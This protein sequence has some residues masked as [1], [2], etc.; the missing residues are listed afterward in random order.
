MLS[1]FPIWDLTRSRTFQ[2][3]F[4]NEEKRVVEDMVDMAG[5]VRV[6]SMVNMVGRTEFCS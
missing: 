5:M 4:W 3:N 2:R 1:S 6:V